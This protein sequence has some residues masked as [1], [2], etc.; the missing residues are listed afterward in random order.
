MNRAGLCVMLDSDKPHL[1][2]RAIF[3]PLIQFCTG[4]TL[5]KLNADKTCFFLHFQ[6]GIDE[7]V[8]S[9]G[10]TLYHLKEGDTLIGGG[11][12]CSVDIVLKGPS[13][14]DKHC[15]INLR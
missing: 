15:T 5:N 11:S 4:S 9:T 6:V 7:D 2:S 10:I 13:I 14:L 1:V 12:N 8:L 3:E